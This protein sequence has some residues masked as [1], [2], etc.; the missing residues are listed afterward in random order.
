MEIIPQQS[1]AREVR[2]TGKPGQAPY[3]F[4][5]KADETT[6]KLRISTDQ[7]RNPGGQL[8]VTHR[9]YALLGGSLENGKN[10][11]SVLCMESLPSSLTTQDKANANFSTTSS[12]HVLSDQES[13]YP[14]GLAGRAHPDS[15]QLCHLD[16]EKGQDLVDVPGNNEASR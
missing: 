11:N 5:M 9:K 16:C 4:P 1:Q 13:F 12:V 7:N 2:Q 8:Y 10:P 15:A 14:R 6:V 3:H